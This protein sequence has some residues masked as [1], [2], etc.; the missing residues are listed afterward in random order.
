MSRPFCETRNNSPCLD[1]PDRVPACSDRCERYKAWADEI[2]R[3][4]HNRR[5]CMEQRS[6]DAK[7]TIRRIKKK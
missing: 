2:H 1:C 7:N 5:A 3:I 4:S 6:E